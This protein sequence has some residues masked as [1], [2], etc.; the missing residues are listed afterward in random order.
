MFFGSIPALVTPFKDGQPDL[1]AF[2]DFV[3]WQ[4][5]SGSHGLVPCGTT[6][7][8]ATMEPDEH[9]AVVRA[10]VLQANGRV[11]VI[12]GAG[13]NATHRAVAL[14]EMMQNENVDAVLVSAPWYNK[15]SQEGIY[16]HF[17]KISEVGIPIIVYNVP[18]RT[19]VDISVATLGRIAK[20]PNVVGLKDATGKIFRVPQQ[21]EA[22]GDNFIQLSGDDPSA[23][24]FYEAGGKGCI[25]VTANVLPRECAAVQD[26]MRNGEFAQ[27]RKLDAPLQAVHKAMFADA[28]PAPAKYVL[29]KAGFMAEELR[30]PMV[31]CSE[32][33]RETVDAALAGFEIGK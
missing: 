10:C 33:A 32:A 6:G 21:H 23:V 19:V 27:A 11:P 31:P 2:A 28:S 4:I 14:C 18:G 7:E 17:A 3:E 12:A 29:A 20:L 30:L 26:A 16:A 13:S 15:P 24:D 22:C 8:A 9:R 1:Q 25:S 5:T